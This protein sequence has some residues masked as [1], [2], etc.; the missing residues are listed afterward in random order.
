MPGCENSSANMGTAVKCCL[1]RLALPGFLG[2]GVFMVI[3]VPPTPQRC[4]AWM[5]LYAARDAP[6]AQLLTGMV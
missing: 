3:R 4:R 5:E 1:L 2:Y 6:A